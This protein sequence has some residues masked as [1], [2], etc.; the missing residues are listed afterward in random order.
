[1]KITQKEKRMILANR[2]TG[3]TKNM[4]ALWYRR[5]SSYNQGLVKIHKNADKDS[6]DLL[7]KIFK[8]FGTLSV[9]SDSQVRALNMFLN[10]HNQSLTVPTVR[11]IV[12]K[13]ALELGI[14]VPSKSF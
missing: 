6:K 5:D 10:L 7:K 2:I 14:K 12:F 4:F 9:M 8:E 13:I 11:N 3:G 1:M